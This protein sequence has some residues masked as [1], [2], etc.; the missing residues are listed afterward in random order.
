MGHGASGG[1]TPIGPEEGFPTE[2]HQPSQEWES[3]GVM[4]VGLGA[5]VFRYSAG[6]GGSVPLIYP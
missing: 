1:K 3:H 4:A 5:G 2:T 6:C